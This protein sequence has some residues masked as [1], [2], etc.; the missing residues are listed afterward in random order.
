M[1]KR[2]TQK[3]FIERSIELNGDKLGYDRVNY[4]NA[5]TEVWL[6]CKKCKKYFKQK[7]MYHLNRGHG[8]PHCAGNMKS[9]KEEFIKKSIKIHGDK[10]DFSK[11]VYVNSK[12]HVILICKTCGREFKV[13]PDSHINRKSGCPWCNNSFYKTTEEYVAQAKEIHG[14]RVLY[15]GV[16]YVNSKTP[17]YPSCPIHGVFKCDPH[18]HLSDGCGCPYC[19]ISKLEKFTENFLKEHDVKYEVFKRFDWLRNK[20][21]LNLD[22]YLPE[23]NIGIECQGR[24]HF[25]PISIFGGEEEFKN[26]QERDRVKKQQCE[27][28]G[29]KLLYINKKKEIKEVLNFLIKT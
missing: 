9:N 29:V 3:Q 16:V 12:T 1:P 4:V 2:L 25:E 13:T 7:P 22:F 10:F 15:D 17:I 8:C 24:Q 11:V 23:Y 19:N 14:G 21:P 5:H 20:K 28:N 27:E 26:T 6:Y 18:H